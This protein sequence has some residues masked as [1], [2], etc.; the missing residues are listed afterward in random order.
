MSH[1]AWE[2]FR[3]NQEELGGVAGEKDVEDNLPG[4][5]CRTGWMSGGRSTPSDRRQ[6][7]KLSCDFV[8]LA[9]YSTTTLS[10]EG[11]HFL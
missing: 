8:V 2:H 4:C 6:S 11:L 9:S 3:S 1:L 7:V 5:C 10:S